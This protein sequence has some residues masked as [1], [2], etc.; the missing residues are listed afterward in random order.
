MADDASVDLRLVRTQRGDVKPADTDRLR[1]RYDTAKQ[2]GAL[3]WPRRANR[4]FPKLRGNLCW[5]PGCVVVPDRRPIAGGGLGGLPACVADVANDAPI[6][7]YV[8]I[9]LRINASAYSRKTPR[10]SGGPA[11][12]PADLAY[13]DP[14]TTTRTPLLSALLLATTLAPAQTAAQTIPTVSPETRTAVRQLLGDILLNGEAYEYD[15]QLA[16]TIGPRLTGSPNYL[17]AAEWAQQQLRQLGLQNVHTEAWT[18]PATWEPD[19]AV[20]RILTPVD[21][22]FHIYSVGWSPST[23]AA[24]IQGPVLYLP[25]LTT[26][27]LDGLAGRIRGSVVLVDEASYGEKASIDQ[28][29]TGLD[30]LRS[31][32]PLAILTPG[33]PNGTETLTS[34][35]FSGDIDSVPE[36]EIGAED[37]LLLKRLLDR[38]SDSSPVTVQFTLTNRIRK[39]VPIP[40]VVAEIPGSDPALRD[41]VVLIGAHLDSWQPG[42]GAQDNGT[43][44]ATVLEAARAIHALPQPP[45][46]T[47]RFVLFGGEEEGL[48]GSTAY[49]R[50]HRA[51][52]AHIDAVLISDTGA[53]PAKGWY[54]M[55]R[56]D[57]KAA[58]K[59]VEPLLAGL[60]SNQTSD[61]TEFLFET[62]HAAFDVLGVPTLVL[63]NDTDVYFKLHHKASDT[64]DSVIEKDL[65][66]GVATT[67]ITAFA[68][69]DSPEPFAPHLTP[70]Q[71]QTFLKRS[72]NLDEYNFLKKIGSLP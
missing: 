26:G 52:L 61:D 49:V 69:A 29:F 9:I 63:W 64:F 22:T 23:P 12:L 28:I 65:N 67:A 7:K 11:S 43:G 5:A 15:R 30:N 59:N 33:G 58:L 62:D 17:R 35:N 1:K 71:V 46:R 21:H 20:G 72:N 66:Q 68:L 45:R 6:A 16:D 44:V 2:G 24:G 40:N 48:L 54:L 18:I 27:V 32:A 10:S 13:T 3:G 53:Q 8:P 47:L 19:S 41:Q 31:H 38:A 56:E 39:Q 34:L 4:V 37:A 55:G 36:A 50:A 25:A 42:T 57:E 60:G 51:D 14:V 70:A